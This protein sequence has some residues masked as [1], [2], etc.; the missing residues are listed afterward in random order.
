LA[1]GDTLEDQNWDDRTNFESRNRVSHCFWTRK[2]K[3]SVFLAKGNTV[4]KTRVFRTFVPALGWHQGRRVCM[5]A[6]CGSWVL[7]PTQGSVSLLT[8]TF[9]ITAFNYDRSVSWNEETVYF[10]FERRDR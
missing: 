1:G 3:I 9:H 5:A 4:G 10:D 2:R 7:S 8:S 6:G